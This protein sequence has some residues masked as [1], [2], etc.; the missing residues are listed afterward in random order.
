MQFKTD[1]SQGDT[2]SK[3]DEFYDEMKS[4]DPEIQQQVL[5]TL[6]KLYFIF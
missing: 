3:T 4:A 5:K 2:G 6:K 1:T